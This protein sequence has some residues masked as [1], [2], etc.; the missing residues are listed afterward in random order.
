[1]NPFAL[2]QPT[3]FAEANELR[4][5]KTYRLPVLKA[6]GMD[7]LDHLKEGILNPDLLINVNT[8]RSEKF[9]GRP[10]RTE[11][12]QIAV[13]GM[14]TLADLATSKHLQAES[15]VLAQAAGDAATPQVRNVATVAGNLLQRPRCWYY[16]SQQFDCLKKGGHSCFSVEGEN[17]F[18]AIFSDG[19][20]Y[21]VHPSNLAPALYVLNATVHLTGSDRNSLFISDLFH[22]PDEQI[23]TEHRLT[24]NE[25]VTHITIN[26]EP[27]SGF[28]AIKEKQSSDWPLVMAAVALALNDN[29]TKIIGARVCAGAVAP[30]PYPLPSVESALKGLD[31]HDNDAIKQACA[32][33]ANGATPMTQNAYK[34]KLLPVAIH[35]ALRKAAGLKVE[36]LNS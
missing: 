13:E 30:T 4:A 21:I 17:K 10:V 26:A 34:T 18:H 22:N 31:P 20:C 35:R 32:R 29:K 12:Y 27:Y 1:M 11:G 8:L 19:P 14:A 36:D 24:E 23:R 28:Y 7:L 3:T 2:A 16:R 6:G 33:A 15:P 25:I 5:D 9:T